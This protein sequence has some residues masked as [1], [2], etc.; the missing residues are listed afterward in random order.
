MGMLL[1]FIALCD[2]YEL[3]WMLGHG[4]CLGAVR[5]KGFIPWDDDL[6]LSM[7]RRDFE[8]L[9]ELLERGNMGPEYDYSCP[10][11]GK[12]AP[13]MFMKIY[14]KGTRMVEM[15]QE[16]SD[17]PKGV[18]LDVFILDG[19]P[20]GL[21]LRKMKGRLANLLRLISNMVLE[22]QY[23]LSATQIEFYQQ[24]KK[25]NCLMKLRRFL[26]HVFGI[27]PHRFWIDSFDS[28]VKDA[29]TDTGFVTFPTGR[30]LYNGEL[31]PASV[32]FPVRR[33]IFEGIDV[34]VPGRAEE[35]LS[36]L[37]GNDYMQLPPVEK[38]ERH[39]IVDFDLNAG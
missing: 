37:Y 24:D 31:L 14:K 1:D 39:F 4:S 29:S 18:F 30:K 15:G 25:T 13:C 6:D 9:K 26:G 21:L 8:K 32:F 5:H 16:F 19:V 20:E 12:D 33:A 23:P 10:N 35:Y 17:Y 2:K 22:A 7:P 38:R 34:N 36:H 27:I 11:S 28:F 3:T